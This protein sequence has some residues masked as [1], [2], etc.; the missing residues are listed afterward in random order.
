[1][2]DVRLRGAVESNEAGFRADDK[3]DPR[4]EFLRRDLIDEILERRPGTAGEN[5]EF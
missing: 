2:A 3:L 5:G 4:I 1:V